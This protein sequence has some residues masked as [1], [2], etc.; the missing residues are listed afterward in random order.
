MNQ[1]TFLDQP[2]ELEWLQEAHGVNTVGYECAILYG[3]EDAPD[4][5]EVYARNHV[6]CKP[7]TYLPDNLRMVI[8]ERGEETLESEMESKESEYRKT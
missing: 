2:S 5:V 8:S 6:H 3:N 7:N 1:T 4:K